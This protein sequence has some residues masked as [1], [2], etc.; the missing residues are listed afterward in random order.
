MKKYRVST[1]YTPGRKHWYYDTIEKA[2]RKMLKL[3]EDKIRGKL[4]EWK[5][6]DWHSKGDSGASLDSKCR[7][8]AVIVNTLNVN[9]IKNEQSAKLV[10]EMNKWIPLEKRLELM[11]GY[12]NET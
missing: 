8:I 1:V 11:E 7:Y 4:Y 3:Y 9:P 5:N 6:L 12:E 10:I 2:A